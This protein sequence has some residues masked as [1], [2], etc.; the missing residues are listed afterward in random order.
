MAAAAI[1][2]RR[3]RFHRGRRRQP[4]RHIQSEIAKWQKLVKDAGLILH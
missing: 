4:D 2:A 3:D 1:G